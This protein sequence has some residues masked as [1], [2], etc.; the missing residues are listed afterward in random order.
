MLIQFTR[1][2]LEQDGDQFVHALVEFLLRLRV[3]EEVE[4]LHADGVDG[5][6]CPADALVMPLLRKDS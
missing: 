2:D 3:G 4:G 5:M 6:R 1:T